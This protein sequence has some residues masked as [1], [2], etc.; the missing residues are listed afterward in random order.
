[1][2]PSPTLAAAGTSPAP[3]RKPYAV[4]ILKFVSPQDGPGFA[5]S[6]ALSTVQNGRP[7]RHTIEFMPWVR[8]FRVTYK[9]DDGSI[10][11]FIPE[12]RVACWYPAD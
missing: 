3:D 9:G 2:K 11:A 6:S 10:T 7:S 12:H 8:A 5:V 4:K 1:M